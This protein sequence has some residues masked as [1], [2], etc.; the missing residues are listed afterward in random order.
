MGDFEPGL[1]IWTLAQLADS[2]NLELSDLGLYFIKS[3]YQSYFPG[4]HSQYIVPSFASVEY[5][6]HCHIV[7]EKIS[8]LI[9][10]KFEP[11]LCKVRQYKGLPGV[12]WNN[13]LILFCDREQVNH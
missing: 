2:S 13:I 1:S 12:L 7:T 5:L 3:S 11:I 4:I 10:A 6:H 9:F 8:C